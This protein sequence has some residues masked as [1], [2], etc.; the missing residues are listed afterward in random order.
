M[1]PKG[2]L[3]S[4]KCIHVFLEQRNSKRING[5][6]LGKKGT[7]YKSVLLYHKVGIPE[8]NIQNY[9]VMYYFIEYVNR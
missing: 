1:C 9:P 2:F 5:L 6:V 3:T 4:F 8:G 7:D